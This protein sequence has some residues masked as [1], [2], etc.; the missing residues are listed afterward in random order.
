LRLDARLG[1]FIGDSFFFH[2]Y[3]IIKL[4]Y[5]FLCRLCESSSLPPC[6]M[7]EAS[8]GQGLDSGAK[9]M[10]DLDRG[11][12]AALVDKCGPEIH[13]C[14]LPYREIGLI[15]HIPVWALLTSQTLGGRS[16]QPILLMSWYLQ[17]IMSFLDVPDQIETTKGWILQ[18][19][20]HIL[21]LCSNIIFFLCL[22]SKI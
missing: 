5:V 10:M 4:W 2:F 13:T 21:H 1:G 18:Y 22:T 16:F 9:K 7:I 3:S 8:I 20:V 17:T 14:H 11:L 19:K 12:L 15:F 6:Q